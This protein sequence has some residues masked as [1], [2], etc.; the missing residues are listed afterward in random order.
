[1][2]GVKVTITIVDKASKK[3]ENIT[4]SVARLEN[5]FRGLSVDTPFIKLN[6][7]ADKLNKK[8]KDTTKSTNVLVKALKG[9]ATSYLGIMALRTTINA[10][11][12]YTSSN[13]RLVAYGMTQQGMSKADASQFSS[14]S[15]DKIY[16]AS[17][18]A[19]TSAASMRA[20]VSKVMTLAG[21]SFGNNIDNAIRFQEIMAKSYT[22]GGASA[23]EQSSSMY[24]LIQALGAGVLQGDE[25]RSVREGA[26]LAYQAIEKF[27]Q[28]IYGADQNLKDLASQGKIT[29]DMVVAAIMQTG[30]AVDATFGEMNLTFAQLW[31][32]FK[33]D[34]SQAFRPLLTQL[35]E[36]GNSESFQFIVDQIV[37]GIYKVANMLSVVINILGKVIDW[38]ADNWIAF[39]AIIIFV[40]Q[41]AMYSLRLAIAKVI[42]ELARKAAMW[43][44]ANWQ[45]LLVYATVI[46]L[47]LVFDKFAKKTGDALK[48]LGLALLAFAGVMLIVGFMMKAPLYTVIGLIAL[49]VAAFA[50]AGEYIV[51]AMAWVGASLWNGILALVDHFFISINWISNIFVSFVNNFVNIW[52]D[53]IGTVIHMF[54]D[55]ASNIIGVIESIAKAMDKVFGTKLAESVQGWREGLNTMVENA[56][57]KYGTGMYEKVLNEVNLSS[58]SLGLSRIDATDAYNA[59]ADWFGGIRNSAN[60]LYGKLG[61]GFDKNSLLGGDIEALNTSVNDI[62]Y[63]T[64]NISKNMELT[65]DDLRYLRQIAEM[66]A[67][68]RFTTAEIK[69]DMTNNNSVSGTSDIEGLVGTLR[70]RLEDEMT[71][72]A[73]G[74]HA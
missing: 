51:G 57:N 28:G 53:P 43:A 36:I 45:M 7:G 15:M 56:A 32:K 39:A 12:N 16:A 17:Q 72:L 20:N 46:A 22:L 42:V 67:I 55:L 74:V 60:N 48:A 33:N 47:I 58:E 24:Q 5:Q 27:A 10:A 44:I 49:V 61:A 73:A 8:L 54:G 71:M 41:R 52:R 19:A 64:D 38:V 59:G 3:V 21:K 63:D 34:V 68:N 35:A 50:I 40:A 30:E 14:D 13:N 69:I 31:D 23:A 37:V 9:L 25:L 62:A 70:D 18:R 6:D 2:A 4:R 66:E 65:S 11:D 29:S 26:P 1:M